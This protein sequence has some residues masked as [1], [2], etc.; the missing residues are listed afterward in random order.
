[1]ARK[2]SEQKVPKVQKNIYFYRADMGQN[3]QGKPIPLNIQ[4]ALDTL[5]QMDY[6]DEGRYLPDGDGNPLCCW[7]PTYNSHPR[8]ILG[9]IRRSGLPLL[10]SRGQL[11]NLPIAEDQGITELIHIVFFPDNIVGFDFNFY[12]P[13]L[14][15]LTRY[16]SAKAPDTHPL[17]SFQP[18]L[19]HDVLEQLKKLK[20]LKMFDLR[21]RK[22]YAQKVKEADEN[23]GKA[24]EMAA[25]LSDAEQLEIILKP[26]RNS[27]KSIGT[28][29][30]D[31]V[32]KLAGR[33]DVY[34]EASCFKIKGENDS[35][36]KID[37]IDLLRD[38]LIAKKTVAKR[39]GRS[40]AL[41]EESV[42]QAIEQ[43]YTELK[44]QLAQAPQVDVV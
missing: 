36:G 31:G 5:S 2:K 21:I 7:I 29:I 14:N 28:K 20:S 44:G 15:R 17:V 25:G 1:M 37:E 40:K 22:S 8:L 19:R 12:G 33:D 24:F 4:S 16:L 43:A 18:L 13:R 23:L 34:T 35:T 9:H 27:K 41:D 3:E 11:E 39:V 42:F 30:L 26:E 32:K 38:Q 6:S 10:E